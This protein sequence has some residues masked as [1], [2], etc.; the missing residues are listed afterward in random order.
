[1]RHITAVA[2]G[3]LIA[4]A[5]VAGWVWWSADQSPSSAEIITLVRVAEQETG[6]ACVPA[7][8]GAALCTP[9]YGVQYIV[10][11]EDLSLNGQAAVEDA[12]E[13]GTPCWTTGPTTR[14]CEVHGS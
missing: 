10:R 1:V 5:V 6:D 2:V 11:L 14:Q 8:D 7:P 4:C 13:G 9:G 3:L 12:A